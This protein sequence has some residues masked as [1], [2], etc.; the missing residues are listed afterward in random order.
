LNVS[1]GPES[2]LA[3]NHQSDRKFIGNKNITTKKPALSWLI[4]SLFLY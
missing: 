4:H 2:A 1:L 3:L